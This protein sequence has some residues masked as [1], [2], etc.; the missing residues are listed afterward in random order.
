M[1]ST[2]FHTLGNTIIA[3]NNEYSNFLEFIMLEL[4]GQLDISCVLLDNIKIFFFMKGT[5][6]CKYLQYRSN[7]LLP[8]TPTVQK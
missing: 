5:L 2:L 1:A 8:L 3:L 6:L 7:S 4:Q